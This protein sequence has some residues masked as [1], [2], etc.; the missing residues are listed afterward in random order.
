MP[1]LSKFVSGARCVAKQ[2]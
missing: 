2:I 1:M